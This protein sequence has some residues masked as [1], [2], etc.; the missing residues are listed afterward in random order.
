MTPVLDVRGLAF[1]YPGA[2]MQADWDGREG[3]SY[4]RVELRVPLGDTPVGRA[5]PAIDLA[6]GGA[7]RELCGT[8]SGAEAAGAR[9]S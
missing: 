6:D 3:G 2:R 9:P 4:Y 8:G 7:D 1:A 5:N